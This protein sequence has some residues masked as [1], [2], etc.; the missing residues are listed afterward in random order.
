MPLKDILKKKHH[1]QA[2]QTASNP[3]HS[4][5]APPISPEG[6]TFMRSDTNTQEIITPPTFAGDDSFPSEKDLSSPEKHKR[7]SL[8]HRAS[9]NGVPTHPPPVPEPSPKDRPTERPGGVR[10]ISAQVMRFSNRDRAGSTGSV[11]LPQELPEIE[12]GRVGEVER[13]AK[14]EERATILANADVRVSEKGGEPGRDGAVGGS[15]RK[16]LKRSVSGPEG[17]VRF[18]KAWK[19]LTGERLLILA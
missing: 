17:D 6:F 13:E 11:T 18:C 19:W 12:G 3:P 15:E 9:S 7:R 10:R 4:T 14:W 8:F 16:G 1:I 5:L 2:D